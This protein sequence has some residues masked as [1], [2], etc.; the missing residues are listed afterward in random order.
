MDL[1]VKLWIFL[2]TRCLFSVVVP[3]VISQKSYH[4]WSYGDKWYHQRGIMTLDITHGMWR[5]FWH[6][7]GCCCYKAKGHVWPTTALKYSGM[8]TLKHY[9]TKHAKW[10]RQTFF[11]AERG[12]R[13]YQFGH[14]SNIF[15][16]VCKF[17]TTF[18]F[19]SAPPPPLGFWSSHIPKLHYVL[20]LF[21]QYQCFV[22]Y[23]NIYMPKRISRVWRNTLHIYAHK[24]PASCDIIT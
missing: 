21:S 7:N 19:G 3:T 18:K 24:R 10:D 5:R 17:P 12:D 14:K 8:T 16:I 20:L 15:W 9:S 13:N 1:L 22:N 11:S 4:H 6:P 23:I 2:C